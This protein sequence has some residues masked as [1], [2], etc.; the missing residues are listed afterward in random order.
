MAYFIFRMPE[1]PDSIFATVRWASGTM[2]ST[3]IA[4]AGLPGLFNGGLKSPHLKIIDLV[5]V[6]GSAVAIVF[7]VIQVSQFSAEETRSRLSKNIETARTSAKENAALAYQQQCV[8][9]SGLTA[10]QCESLRRIGI[11]LS[12]GGYLSTNTVEALC[13]LPINP[14]NP[15]HAFGPALAEACIQAAYVARAAEEPVMKDLANVDEWKF[16]SRL[17]PIFMISLVALRVMKS[18]AEVFWKVS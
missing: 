16:K 2:I 8:Q 10:E 13:P 9:P 7:A 18:I 14:S 15:P 17:W 5:W 4:F 3:I 12:V 6:L 11:S 1:N